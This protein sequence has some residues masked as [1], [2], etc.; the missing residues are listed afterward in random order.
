VATDLAI[1]LSQT[2]LRVVFLAH[3]AWLRS[4]AIVRTLWRLGITRRNLLEWVPAAQAHRA[5]DLEV[6]GFYRRMRGAILLAAAAGA[7]RGFETRRTGIRR[8]FVVL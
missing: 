4:D 1:G 8:P 2:A 5:L 6:G 7:G 3:S